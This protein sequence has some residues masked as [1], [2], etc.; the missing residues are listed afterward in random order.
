[1]PAPPPE[2]TG[3]Q[4]NDNARIAVDEGRYGTAC[5]YP[6]MGGY[7]GKA[8]ICIGAMDED[9]DPPCFETWVWH[10][11]D[12]PFDGDET[13]RRGGPPRRLH[14]CDAEHFIEFGQLAIKLSREY[15]GA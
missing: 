15:D 2:P 10:D 6:Q 4:C 3:Q 12:F 9:N 5:W 7:H 1:M 8:I 14:H 13:T 11:G